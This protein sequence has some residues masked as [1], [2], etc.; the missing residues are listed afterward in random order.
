LSTSRFAPKSHLLSKV[1]FTVPFGATNYPNLLPLY[2]QIQTDLSTLNESFWRTGTA[3]IHKGLQ[4]TRFQCRIDQLKLLS[5]HL[6]N[7]VAVYHISFYKKDNC[8]R[9]HPDPHNPPCNHETLAILAMYQLI[10]NLDLELLRYLDLN[11]QACEHIFLG[12]YQTI[13]YNT[14]SPL[15]QEATDYALDLMLRYIKL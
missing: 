5:P 6:I 4:V 7:D 8:H 1:T 15:D 12:E 9:H 2:Q 11:R 13:D 14:L 10:C 3:L